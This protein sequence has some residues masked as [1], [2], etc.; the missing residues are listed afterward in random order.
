MRRLVGVLLVAMSVAVGSCSAFEGGP[1]PDGGIIGNPADNPAVGDPAVTP[2]LTTTI[3]P[4]APPATEAIADI[5]VREA[6]EEQAAI[7]ENFFSMCMESMGYEVA[8]VD[9]GYQKEGRFTEVGEPTAAYETQAEECMDAAQRFLGPPDPLEYGDI[10]LSD[11]ELMYAAMAYLHDEDRL[12]WGWGPGTVRDFAEVFCGGPGANA[13]EPGTEAVQAWMAN[14]I[15]GMPDDADGR[16][17]R[18]IMETAF[19][20]GCPEWLSD[21]EAATR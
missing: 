1:A 21:F 20:H 10:S 12:D 9:V 15:A 19:T 16:L 13:F 17:Q 8:D 4:T 7:A 18:G 6:L 14:V 5:R 11:E 3:P 2:A